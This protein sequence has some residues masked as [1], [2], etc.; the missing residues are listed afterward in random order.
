MKIIKKKRDHPFWHAGVQKDYLC[1][2]TREREYQLETKQDWNLFRESI[3]KTGEL[4]SFVGFLCSSSI[5]FPQDSTEKQ[6]IIDLVEEV[7]HS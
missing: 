2:R 1:I 7:F 4:E 6:E 3:E 5:D